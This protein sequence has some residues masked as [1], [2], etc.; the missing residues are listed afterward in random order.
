MKE[1]I[2]MDM[3]QKMENLRRASALA[4]QQGAAISSALSRMSDDDINLM[5]DQNE[6]LRDFIS[7]GADNDNSNVVVNYANQPQNQKSTTISFQAPWEGNLSSVPTTPQ[8]GLFQVQ[9]NY[10]MNNSGFWGQQQMNDPRLIMY[11]KHPGMRLYNIN[12]YMF[13]DEIQLEDYYNACEAQRKKQEDINYVMIRL[14]ARLEGTQEALDY[15]EQFQFKPGDQIVQE[16]QEAQRK[17][18]EERNKELYGDQTTDSR[19]IVYDRY[20]ANGYRFQKSPSFQFVDIETG[21]VTFE[22]NHHTDENG[23]SYVIK[24]VAEDRKLAYEIQQLHN[25]FIQDARFKQKFAE[26]FTKDYFDNIARWDSWNAQ[27]L[28]IAQKAQLYE[29]SRVDWEKQSKL[30]ER[31]LQTAS[32]SREKFHDILIK[33]CHCEL[34]YANRSDFFSLSY[35]FE[36]DM[37]YKTLISTPEEMQ[38]DPMVHTKLQQEYEV[39]RR[40]FMNKVNSGDLGCNMKVDAHYHP[41]FPKPNIDSLTLEDYDKP[42]NQVMYTQIVTPEIATPNMFIPNNQSKSDI[43][44]EELAKLGVFLDENGLPIPK[45]RTI[46]FMT[47]DDETGEII[48]QQEFDITGSQ[49]AVVTDDM[50]VTDL[51]NNNLF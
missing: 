22:V 50:S 24:S 43:S 27:G 13:Y 12:P 19:G 47:V 7:V 23:E 33:C 48:S 10:Y 35:D 14:S 17:A 41:T 30:I 5:L 16:Q 37:H 49:G 40:M 2:M 36:R 28:T 15:A 11:N 46:G 38:N 20:D 1:G 18:I 42:E 26:L 9:N 51:I 44:R 39:K 45:E 31:C 6:E 34:D 25:A 3:N 32:Y 4:R 21:E 29:D 8:N